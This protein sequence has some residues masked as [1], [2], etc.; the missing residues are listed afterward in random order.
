MCE[1]HVTCAT[2]L[3]EFSLSIGVYVNYTSNLLTG[4]D[5]S[6]QNART[7]GRHMQRNTCKQTCSGT[8]KALRYGVPWPAVEPGLLPIVQATLTEHVCAKK[9]LSGQHRCPAYV[10]H[11]RVP[12]DTG[13]DRFTHTNCQGGVP[14][15]IPSKVRCALLLQCTWPHHVGLFACSVSEETEHSVMTMFNISL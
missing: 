12:E 2:P 10:L 6:S 9:W 1:I 15:R 3:Q 11:E 8:T 14:C 5:C 13:Q 4:V 7:H